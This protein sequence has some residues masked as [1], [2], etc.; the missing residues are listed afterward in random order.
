M[1]QRF[2]LFA[3]Q[4]LCYLFHKCF[5]L[6]LKI[7]RASSAFLELRLKLYKNTKKNKELP[8][9]LKCDVI[10]HCFS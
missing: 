6:E 7:Q 1:T 8:I 10:L 5:D 4:F 3:N 2:N 9:K